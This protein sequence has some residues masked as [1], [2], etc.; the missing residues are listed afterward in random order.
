MEKPF[1]NKKLKLEKIQ[2]KGGWTYVSV[3]AK[4]IVTRRAFGMIK[5]KGSIDNYNIKDFTI[6][7]TKS[8]N[9]FMPVKKEI[10]K[11]IGKEEGGWVNLVLYLEEDTFAVPEEILECLAH[12][13]K[14]LQFFNSLTESEQKAYINRIKAAK[15]D[16]QK[17][18]RI[19]EMINALSKGLK[20]KEDF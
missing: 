4:G 3:P 6:W 18:K 12:E 8:G 19:A 15:T 5:V 7:S 16:A 11:K 1:I 13:T 14:A 20:F 9:F 10:R 2:G 17:V